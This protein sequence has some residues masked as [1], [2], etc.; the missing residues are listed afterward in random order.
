MSILQ[1]AQGAQ[2]VKS[3]LEVQVQWVQSKTPSEAHQ[4]LRSIWGGNEQNH[5][6]NVCICVHV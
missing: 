5:W 6:Q 3:G 4:E 2:G 1:R